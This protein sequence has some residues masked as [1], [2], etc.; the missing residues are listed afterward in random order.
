MN[1]LKKMLDT[2][3]PNGVEYHTLGELGE[4]YGGLSGKSKDD[5]KDG[6][7]NFITY[8]SVFNNPAL[9][10]NCS[11]KV[12]IAPGEKQRKIK[13][14]DVIFTGSSETP[15]ECAFSSV[16]C[17]EP[18]EDYYL[19]SFCFVWEVNDK[20]L[21]NPHFL[22]QLFRTNELRKQLIKTAS[23][24]TRFNVSKD[25]M[26]KVKI[27]VPPIE[28]QNEIVRILDSF[29]ELTKKLDEEL[30]SRKKQYE[31]YHN[32]LFEFKEKE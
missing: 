20:E 32:K 7:A 21:F 31:Y 26:R 29:V 27:P 4:F 19:N 30:T 2:L 10:L 1:K 14:L 6:N 28:V 8:V 16:V 22:K 13:Y 3:C 11:A 18:R 5:F 12:K 25:K 15:D 9:D 17:E 24:V 23:G